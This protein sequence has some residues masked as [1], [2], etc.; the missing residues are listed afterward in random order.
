MTIPLIIGGGIAGPVTAMALQRAG[1]DS[2]IFE[3]YG[4]GAD[5]VGTFLTLAVNGLEALRILGLHDLVCDLGVESPVMEISDGRGKRLAV[6]RQPSRT[7]KRAD[8]YR[9]LRDEA[10]RRGVRIHYGKRLAHASVTPQGVR[11]GFADGT[12]AEG[13]L[14]IG[15][16]GLRS[17]TRTLIDPDAPRARYAGLLNTGGFADGVEVPGRPGVNY[18]IFGRRCFFG[19]LIHPDGQVWWFANPPSRK[20]L[21]REE[22]AKID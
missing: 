8:L 15:A 22:L 4:R 6:L 11:A 5:G 9:A 10:V 3:E 16:D 14:L 20:E 19:Y 7:V 18:F 1:V 21:T 12:H 13:D 2:E 17:R